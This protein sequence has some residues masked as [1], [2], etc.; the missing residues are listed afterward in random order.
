[1]IH[2]HAVIAMWLF[3]DSDSEYKGF[4]NFRCF[5]LTQSLLPSRKTDYL[6]IF[7]LLMVMMAHRGAH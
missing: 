1:M 7:F 6:N 4:Y 5:A 3:D 2:S